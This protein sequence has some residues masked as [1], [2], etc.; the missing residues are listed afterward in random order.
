[1][2]EIPKKMPENIENATNSQKMLQILENAT[3]S[4]KYQKI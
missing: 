2:L 1:M 3:K 4:R